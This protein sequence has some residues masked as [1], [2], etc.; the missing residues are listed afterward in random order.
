MTSC[1]LKPEQ[2]TLPIFVHPWYE[3]LKKQ[4]NT[5]QCVSPS[6]LKLNK[7]APGL[8]S[9]EW[10]AGIYEGEGW[11]T[12]DKK[13]YWQIAI[14]MTDVDVLQDFYDI[15]R[16]G[17]LRGPYHSPSMKTHHLPYYRWCARTA[18]DIA[19]IVQEFYPYMGERRRAKFDEFIHHYYGC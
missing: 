12:R 18:S 9:I 10:A 1:S 16:L 6:A 15:V 19:S 5:T 13:N 14:K 7:E 4:E 11:M 2:F 3:E 8:K 17:T